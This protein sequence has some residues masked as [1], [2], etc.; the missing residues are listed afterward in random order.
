MTLYQ[1]VKNRPHPDWVTQHARLGAVAEIEGHKAA[2]LV[3][4]EFLRDTDPGKVA[5]SKTKAPTEKSGGRRRKAMSAKNRKAVS[6]RMKKYWADRRK[7]K[8][9]SRK[10]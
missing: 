4:E 8:R 7:A 3:L 2:I 6:V 5:T 9:A 1:T 10:K